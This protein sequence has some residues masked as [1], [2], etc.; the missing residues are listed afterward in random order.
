[1]PSKKES[2]YDKSQFPQ[3]ALFDTFE[4]KIMAYLS[5]T[6]EHKIAEMAYDDER[7]IWVKI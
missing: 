1:M 4:K 2:N 5:P 3:W 6:P 7:Y